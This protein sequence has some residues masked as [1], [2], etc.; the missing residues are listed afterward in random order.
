M[1]QK[2]DPKETDTSSGLRKEMLD[3]YIQALSLLSR[4]AFSAV[5]GTFFEHMNSQDANPTLRIQLV[6]AIRN[7]ILPFDSKEDIN[8]S[9]E[10]VQY[11]AEQIEK[12]PKPDVIQAFSSS[13]G[14]IL[15]PVCELQNDTKQYHTEWREFVTET[16]YTL[17]KALKKC[18]DSLVG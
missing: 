18:K 3:T 4:C 13:L 11:F 15:M 9:K 8:Q 7:I 17:K 6:N 1:S 5:T 14:E 2:K 16:Y 10:L 12:K